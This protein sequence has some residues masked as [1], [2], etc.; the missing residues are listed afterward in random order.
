M[1]DIKGDT[2]SL[3]YGLHDSF[4]F[5]GVWGYQALL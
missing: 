2:K 1:G 5:L 3:G 4:R